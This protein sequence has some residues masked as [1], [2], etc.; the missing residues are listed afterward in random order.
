MLVLMFYKIFYK[1]DTNNF[2]TWWDLIVI[3]FFNKS[4]R[5]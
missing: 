2:Y 1:I 5:G 3:Y 4:L